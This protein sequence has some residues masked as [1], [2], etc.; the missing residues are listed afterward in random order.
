M[1]NKE[2]KT[3]EN[4][5]KYGGSAGL[6]G[7]VF[8]LIMQLQTQGLNSVREGQVQSQNVVIEKTMANT[9]LAIRNQKEIEK[10]KDEIMGDLRDLK[11]QARVDNE[12]LREDL[13]KLEG[14]IREGA[15]D[16]WTRKEHMI[17]RS[18]VQSELTT[19]K[20]DIKDLRKYNNNNNKGE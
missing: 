18:N 16:K 8:S 7:L 13:A 1:S 5:V 12:R 11:T 19:I 20:E 9:A 4:V 6:G 17:F 2:N 15:G 14:V 3:I 10:L